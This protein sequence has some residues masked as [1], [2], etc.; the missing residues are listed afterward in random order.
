MSAA[1]GLGLP[2]PETKASS[3]GDDP[4]DV[5]LDSP[6]AVGLAA[7]ALAIAA[8]A[9]VV[10]IVYGVRLRQRRQRFL[11]RRNAHAIAKADMHADDEGGAP[12]LP[13]DEAV[14]Q[15]MVWP[16]ARVHGCHALRQYCIPSTAPPRAPLHGSTT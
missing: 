11:A 2:V 9:L 15:S 16:D 6:G 7:T 4:G 8:A 1:T 12:T 14:S 10:V 3:A 13:T 5:Q